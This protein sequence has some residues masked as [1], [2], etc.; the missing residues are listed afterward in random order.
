MQAF[1]T[2]EIKVLIATSVI[3]VGVDVPN[4]TVMIVFEAERFGL[5][6]LH[7]LR[8]RIGRGQHRSWCILVASG[9]N[10][11]GTERLKVLEK[12][13]DGFTVAEEDLKLRGPGELLGTAQ[14]G[15]PGLQ[16]GDLVRDQAL[17]N[18]ARQLATEALSQ[19]PT[20]RRYHHLLFTDAEN[21]T[22]S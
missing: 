2:M 7:Q 5:A 17:V 12:T 14:S 18:V 22:L 16:L 8:G 19:D 20:L 21:A 10:P 9:Q 15:L 1:R 4:A 11:E 6:Q 3:E 13:T